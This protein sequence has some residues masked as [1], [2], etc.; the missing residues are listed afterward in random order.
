M[1]IRNGFVSNSSS[2]SFVVRFGDLKKISA[3]MLKVVTNDFSEYLSSSKRRNISSHKKWKSNLRKAFT[4]D[5]IKS[6]EIGI[7]MPSC[8]YDTY[9]YHKKDDGFWITTCHNHNWEFAFDPFGWIVVPYKEDFLREEM[10]KHYYYNVRNGLI[11]SYPIFEEENEYVEKKMQ[12]EC[13]NYF[14][15]YVLDTKKNK[16]CG[17][18]FSHK[19]KLS[20]KEK[21][22]IIRREGVKNPILSLDL[23]N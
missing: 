2:S 17:D 3:A 13:G 20:P 22:E 14:G 9:I 1:K 10:S 15:E 11:H 23:G 8:N 7:T 16:I 21:L 18:C 12:C 5:D 6:G 4:L 19:I